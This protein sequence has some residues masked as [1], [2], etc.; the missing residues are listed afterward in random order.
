MRRPQIEDCLL[1]VLNALSRVAYA[2]SVVRGRGLNEAKFNLIKNCFQLSEVDFV[3]SGRFETVFVWNDIR[4]DALLHPCR[5][6]DTDTLHP[7]AD[8][9]KRHCGTSYTRRYFVRGNAQAA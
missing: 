1:P 9:E 6:K 2:P 7:I 3:F 4:D 8:F 5:S